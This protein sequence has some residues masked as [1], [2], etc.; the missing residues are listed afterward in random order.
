MFL[1]IQQGSSQTSG[2]DGF[3]IVRTVRCV[4]V[5]NEMARLIV[6]SVMISLFLWIKCLTG[7]LDKKRK[8]ERY[9]GGDAAMAALQIRIADHR[10]HKDLLRSTLSN[11]GGE[12]I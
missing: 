12:E 8:G 5:S 2:K 10:R 4:P 1:T 6:T 11:G 7:Q 9:D 3:E